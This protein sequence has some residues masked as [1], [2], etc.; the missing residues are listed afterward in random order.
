MTR[1]PDWRPRLAACLATAARQPFAWG[2]HDCA[3]FVADA[4]A[5]MT[6]EDP[7]AD[8]R[9]RY[10]SFERG[11]ILVRREGFAD[12]VA[13]YAARFAE[14]PPLFAQVGDIA[15]VD[16]DDAQPALGIVQGEAIYVLQPAGLALLALT[17]ARR[18]FRV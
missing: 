15:V 7:A 5:A 6:G 18:A 12:H 11:L 17:A 3:L 14:I 10:T 4:I 1:L 9:G 8:W 16:G 13:W 2:R